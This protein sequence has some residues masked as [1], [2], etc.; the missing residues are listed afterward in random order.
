MGAL[1][2]P[3]RVL[4]RPWNANPLKAWYDLSQSESDCIMLGCES[5][6]SSVPQSPRAPLFPGRLGSGT[7]GEGLSISAL[8]G[9]TP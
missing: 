8:A 9:G 5:S 7:L 1:G 2:G 3:E 4:G 6:H